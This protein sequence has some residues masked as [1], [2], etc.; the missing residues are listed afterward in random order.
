MTNR[1]LAS[2]QSD[3]TGLT[4]DGVSFAF[5]GGP[6][7]LSDFSL[8]FGT[9]V[10]AILGPSGLGKTTLLRLIAGRLLPRDG[11][12]LGIDGRRIAWMGQSGGLMPWASVE[13]NVSLGARLRGENHDRAKT[14]DILARV[15]L[16]GHEAKRPAELSGGMRQRAALARTILEN[17]EVVV[18]DEPF[19]H[20]DAVAKSR[21]FALASRELSG[22]IV[23]MVTHDLLDA[24]TLAGRA[25]VLTGS[26]MRIR[27]DIALSGATPRAPRDPSLTMHHASILT[28]LEGA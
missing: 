25:I 16:S 20:L 13:E 12:I 6:P 7:M 8:S 9:G 14:R 19:V 27:A 17:A 2:A 11:R 3:A 4:I 22:R 28:A 15:G 1:V 23:V 10:T 18:L 24:L 21:L 5:P 26:P